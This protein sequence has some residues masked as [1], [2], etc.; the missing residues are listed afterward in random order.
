[1]TKVN[2]IDTSEHV[3]KTQYLEMKTDDDDEKIPDT[4]GLLKNRL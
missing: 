4:N 1:M 3:L 2:A